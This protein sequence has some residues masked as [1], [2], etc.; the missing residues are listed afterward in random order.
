MKRHPFDP[1]AAVLGMLVVALGVAVMSGAVPTLG[2]FGTWLAI[3]VLA[4]GV[5]MV[6]WH[7]D[8][9]PEPGP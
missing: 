6:P 9:T 7:R 4:V 3:G 1:V 5:A 2:G 8:T